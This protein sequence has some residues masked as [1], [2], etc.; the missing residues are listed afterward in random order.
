[1]V[2]AA[3]VGIVSLLVIFVLGVDTARPA[4]NIETAGTVGEI[5]IPAV[6]LFM[7]YAHK[8]G[9]GA[10]ELVESFGTAIAAMEALKYT[11]SE[12]R[13][14]GSPH[15]FPSGHAT[16]AFAGAGFIQMRYGWVYGIPAYLAASFVGY[17]RVE[18]KNHYWDDVVAGAA[19][20]VGSDLCFVLPYKDVALTP[21]V[22]NG[23]Y[24]I[25]I[26]TGF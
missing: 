9:E 12:K 5:A 4:D 20:G 6:G 26:A 18:S 19:I 24:G 14:D 10:K 16:S 23:F 22:G 1:M 15:S 7:T 21:V 11:V 8:D 2:K 13:P 17:S 3:S 25:R